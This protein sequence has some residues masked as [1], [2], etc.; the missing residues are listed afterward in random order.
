[1]LLKIVAHSWNPEFDNFVKNVY[2][3]DILESEKQNSFVKEY[4]PLLNPIDKF[5]NGLT[6]SKSTWKRVSY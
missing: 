6:R 1:M 5:E 2:N 3:V 4:M